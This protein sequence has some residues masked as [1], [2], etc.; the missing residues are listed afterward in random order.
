MLNEINANEEKVPNQVVDIAPVEPA[1]ENPV[2]KSGK[3]LRTVGIVATVALGVTALGM[4]L[5][6]KY[7]SKKEIDSEDDACEEVPVDAD[8]EEAEEENA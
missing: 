8:F 3:G 6:D 4:W 7:Q 2:A 5:W 1:I